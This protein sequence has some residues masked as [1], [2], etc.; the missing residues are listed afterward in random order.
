M[1]AEVAGRTEVDDKCTRC[2]EPPLALSALGV[3][4][5]HPATSKD[6]FHPTSPLL[7]LGGNDR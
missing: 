2:Q 7:G 6:A 4:G 3:S 1:A 5:Q